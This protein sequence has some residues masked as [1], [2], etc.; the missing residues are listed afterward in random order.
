MTL[1]GAGLASRRAALPAERMNGLIVVCGSAG[2][3]ERG[4]SATMMTEAWQ[5]EMGAD[6]VRLRGE[7]VRIIGSDLACL[8]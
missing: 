3:L 7:Y 8:G 1:E 4:K 2:E 5:D 6:V